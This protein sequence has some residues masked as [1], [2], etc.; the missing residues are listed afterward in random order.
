MI[1][2]LN[3]NNL[4]VIII[5]FFSCLRMFIGYFAPIF[6]FLNSDFDDQLLIAFSHL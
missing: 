3:I 4:S 2:K 5:I 6:Y 1:K